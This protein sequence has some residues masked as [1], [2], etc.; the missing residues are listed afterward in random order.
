[1]PFIPAYIYNDK[2]YLNITNHCTNNCCFCIRNSKDGVGYD[3]FLDKEPT[4]E[5]ILKAVKDLPVS[6]EVTFCGFGEPLLRPE[7]VI[8]VAKEIKEIY[9]SKIRV[10]TNGLAEKALNRKILPSLGGC[11]DTISISLNAH[12]DATYEKV[13]FP[14]TGASSFRYVLDFARESKKYIPHVALSVVD[15][16]GVDIEKCKQLAEQLGIE[17]RIRHFI[18]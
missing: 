1:M 12:D 17:L 14:Q 2:L 13:C 6:D 10:N 16:P 5:E 7:I 15:I 9:G 18:P 11:I 3:L 8:D 4:S